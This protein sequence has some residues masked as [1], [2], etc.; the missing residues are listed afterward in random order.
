MGGEK[1]GEEA[2]TGLG[3]PDLCVTCREAGS[4]GSSAS[5]KSVI[6]GARGSPLPLP[7]PS[8]LTRPRGWTSMLPSGKTLPR[9]ESVGLCVTDELCRH[10]EDSKSYEKA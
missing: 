4:G 6:E 3:P 8:L 9:R 2:D 5:A 1:A 10:H 7:V